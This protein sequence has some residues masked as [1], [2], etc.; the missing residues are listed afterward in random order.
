MRATLMMAILLSL[1]AWQEVLAD[2]VVLRNGDKL[3]GK[4]VKAD[5][6]S[7]ILKTEFAGEVTV[8]WDAVTQ[9]TSDEPLYLSLSDGRIVSGTI[10]MSGDVVEVRTSDARTVTTARGTIQALRSKEEQSAL[11]RLV[12]PGLFELWTGNFTAGLSL[13]SGNAETLNFGLGLAA[14]R[15][16]PRDKITLYA[17]SIYGR[18]STDGFSRTTASAIRVGGRYDRN[19]NRKWFA[20][21]FTDLD[22]D[23]FQ[24]LNLRMVLG[25]GL[26]YRAIRS[27]RTMLDL[28][29]GAA[30][31][32]EFYRGDF[33]DRSSAEAQFG[34]DLSYRLSSRASLKERF[35]IFPNL[36]D[37]GE[38]RI[39]FD[40]GLVTDITK[41]F[42]WQITVSDRYISNPLPG[43]KKNDLLLTT[44]IN[45]K[46]GN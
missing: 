8:V 10:I 15:T 4:I 22:H 12:D 33:N 46:F 28:Y 41:K 39:N 35:V 21:G 27:E 26:G 2:Q 45:V 6:K 40:A 18:D 24:S 44:G 37:T 3:T 16:T 36:S 25:G 32:K 7:L 23:D 30:W 5:G 31:N 14:S 1:I 42:G 29:G 38:Y 43:L 11:D 17:A 34:Q 9:M 20:Y 13:A 19:I